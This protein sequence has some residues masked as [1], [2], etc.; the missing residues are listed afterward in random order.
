M[1]LTGFTALT[2]GELNDS[3]LTHEGRHAVKF[4]KPNCNNK[5]RERVG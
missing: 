1:C 2:T 3:L 4:L 5:N